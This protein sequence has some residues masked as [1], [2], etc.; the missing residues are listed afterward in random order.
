LEESGVTGGNTKIALDLSKGDFIQIFALIS[1]QLKTGNASNVRWRR[2]VSA[3]I[4][5]HA[6]RQIHFVSVGVL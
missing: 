6:S 2:G 1:R 4:E 5:T 3:R